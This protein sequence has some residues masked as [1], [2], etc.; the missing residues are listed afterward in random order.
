MKC[1]YDKARTVHNY[2]MW[3]S[4]ILDEM[5]YVKN[6]LISKNILVTQK[7]QF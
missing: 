6:I 5:D 4:V 3:A 1:M 2:V 7:I